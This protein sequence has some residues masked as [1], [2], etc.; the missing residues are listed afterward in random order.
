MFVFFELMSAVA[1]GLAGFKIEDATSVQGALNFGIVNSLGAY[2]TLMGIGILYAELGALGLPQLSEAMSGHAPDALVVAAFCL[3]CTGFLVKAA[4]VP[5][6]FWLADAHAVAPTPVCLLFSGVMV[7]LGLYGVAR[8]YWIVFSDA[9]PSEAVRRAFLVLGVLTALLGTVM[10]LMQRHL[11]RLLAYS[12][13]AHTGLFL[14]TLGLLDPGGTAGVALYVLGH[15]GVKGALFLLAGIVLNRYGSVDEISLHGR[16]RGMRVVPW[17]YLVGGLALAGMPPFGTGEGKAVSEEALTVAGHPWGPPLF[18]LVSA[19]TAAAVLRAGARIFW[20]LGPV[21]SDDDEGT[22]GDSEE[23]ETRNLP[24]VRWTMLLPVLVLLGGSLAVGSVPAVAQAVSRAAVGFLDRTGY[25]RAALQGGPQAPAHPLPEAA[26]TTTG[27]LLGLLSTA[28]ALGV[29]A[30]AL[31][32]PSLPALL[33]RAG[34]PAGPALG[35]LRGLHS[36]HVGDYVAWLF[37]GTA[38]LGAL[39]GL[40][41]L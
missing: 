9:L 37:V 24:R 30:L 14:A 29:A 32:A 21:P 16:G 33:R 36:G 12:T 41:L 20:G 28:L 13:I 5:F 19:L 27:V 11:K 7:E 18:V 26:W 3:I 1:Y 25:V 6:H 22:T 23:P 31:W 15:A 38:G 2:L 17:L 4:M 35:V 8:L 39:I 40:P 10:C 34:S